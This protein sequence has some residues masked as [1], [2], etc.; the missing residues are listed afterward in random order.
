MTEKPWRVIPLFQAYR[1]EIL[2][3][4]VTGELW[5]AGEAG[6]WEIG[7]SSSCE[8]SL[9]NLCKLNSQ[10]TC[11]HTLLHQNLVLVLHRTPI[12]KI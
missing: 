9:S 5:G 10:H 1:M 12:P 7:G 2:A 4:A 11:L 6:A 8:W 3:S